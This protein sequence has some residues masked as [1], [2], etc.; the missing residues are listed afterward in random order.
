MSDVSLG[1]QLQRA[2]PPHWLSLGL[3]L[4]QEFAIKPG[5]L[6]SKLISGSE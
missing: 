6:E 4:R 5:V 1:A 2:L 3:Y